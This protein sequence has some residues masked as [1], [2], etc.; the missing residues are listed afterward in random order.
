MLS[1]TIVR[2]GRSNVMEVAEAPVPAYLSALSLEQRSL[3][4]RVNAAGMQQLKDF[5]A[6]RQT[7]AF[8]GAGT[9][10]PLYPL[11][12]QLIHVLIDR[13]ANHLSENVALSCRA[14]AAEN[15]DGVVEILRRQVGPADYR[16]ILRDQFRARRDEQSGRS[17]TPVQELVARCNFSG[18]VTT[19]YDPGIVNARMAVR[20]N[21]QATGHASWSDEE[22]L[23]RWRTRD[24][25]EDDE[26]PVLYLHGQHNRPDDIVLATNEYRRAYRG[27][28]ARVLESLL[29]SGRV[30]WLGFSFADARIKAILAA[31]AAEAGTA[32]QP[33]R[34]PRH[35]A[36]MPWDAADDGRDPHVLSA[37]AE[38][39]FDSRVVLYPVIDGDHSALGRLLEELVDRRFPAADA[40]GIERVTRPPSEQAAEAGQPIQHWVHGGD[41]AAHFTGRAEELNRLSRWAGDSEVAL[42]GIT[43]WGGAGKSA[44]VTDWLRVRG[45]ARARSG[46][47]GV[48]AWSFYEERSGEIWAEHLM[49]WVDETIGARG[50]QGSLEQRVLATLREV[51]LILV[52]DGLEVIQETPAATQFGRLLDPLLRN[53]LTAGCQIAHDGIMVLTSRS[54]FPDLERFDGGAARMLEVPPFTP[55]EGAELLGASGGD[56]LSRT[57]RADL[58]KAVDGHALAV[59]ALSGALSDR[60]PVSDVVSLRRDLELAGR[61][62]ARV[63]RV[64]GYYADRLHANDRQVVAVVSLFQRPITP[65]TVL[66]MLAADGDQA[67]TPTE[68]DVESAVRQRLAGLLTWHSNRTISAH[69]L[70]RDSFRALALTPASARLA[71]SIA[72][73]DVPSGQV[74]TRDDAERIVEMIE[75]LLQAGE[76][77]AASELYRARTMNGYVW[78]RLPAAALG[79]RCA[80]AFITHLQDAAGGERRDDFDFYLNEAGLFAVLAG[81][82]Q[83]GVR[84]LGRRVDRAREADDAP[85]LAS[86][87][88]NLSAALAALGDPDASRKAAKEALDVAENA[89]GVRPASYAAL[90]VACDLAGDTREAEKLFQAADSLA[91]SSPTE[92]GNLYSA[93]GVAWAMFL[94]RTGRIDAA[95]QLTEANRARS[96]FHERHQDV[97]RCDVALALCEMR[98]GIGASTR[99]RLHDAVA[100]FQAGEYLMEWAAAL[101]A[102]AELER[103]DGETDR[104]LRDCSAVVSYAAARGLVPLHAFALAKRARC[105]LDLATASGHSGEL[106]RAEDDAEHAHRLATRVRRLPWAELDA[107]STLADVGRAYAA[108]GFDRG[109]EHDQY[110]YALWEEAATGLASRLLPTD[111]HRAP[112]A[113]LGAGRVR[114]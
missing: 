102:R 54:P 21:A 76:W 114:P 37:L 26:L 16:E 78:L 9:S 108:N 42:I 20:P 94:L 27:K 6:D 103:I 72:L 17:W 29:Y 100:M 79:Q 31:V 109:G 8:L 85:R 58:V 49:T 33:G 113:T 73:A 23:D 18:V 60:P 50:H 84:L 66:V 2:L 25:L 98:T 80:T 11:W 105:R 67:T 112:L 51:P 104:A 64:L 24:V 77:T 36:V 82:V 47:R 92:P 15:P 4:L 55:G 110:R 22:A 90:A 93:P 95:I 3:L 65:Q 13:C 111:L 53:V 52:L 75:L 87:L 91:I 57:E 71:S 40:T 44:L 19:N 5:L 96:G 69:P 62:D 38:I 61:T 46:I 59:V 1:E 12:N 74:E 41:P 83:A 30:V 81:D 7:L 34:A 99:Q 39:Q 28:V 35:V 63:S 86:A 89:G 88:R 56:W 97:A 32:E 101:L 14:M 106:E 10:A 107:L 48:F 68:D 70:V 43:A 45:G